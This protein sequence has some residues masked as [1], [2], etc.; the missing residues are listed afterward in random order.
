M[1]DQST[2]PN[3]LI[4]TWLHGTASTK[5]ATWTCPPPPPSPADV[6]HSAIFFTTDSSYAKGA[7]ANIAS[8]QLRSD[9]RIITPVQGGAQSS[10]LR[11]ALL[12]SHP[13]AAQCKWLVDDSAWIAA[14]STGEIMRFACDALDSKAV[15]AVAQAVAGIAV[16]LKK[17]VKGQISNAA[18]Q[19]HAQHCLTRGW[20]EQIVQAAR[21]NGFQVV[22]GLEVDVWANQQAQAAARPCLAVMDVNVIS[23]PTWI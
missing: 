2:H 3:P 11:N 16:Q 4:A 18:I 9:A 12:S 6:P 20:I 8:V 5:F 19:K 14:W 13:L 10:K 7:G 21:K 1:T 17:M 23:P 22:H 15:M